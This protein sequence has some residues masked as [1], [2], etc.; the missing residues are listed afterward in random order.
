MLLCD[1]VARIKVKMHVFRTTLKHTKQFRETN[2]LRYVLLSFEV[3]FMLDMGW[4]Y[5]FW[6]VLLEPTKPDVFKS[7][8]FSI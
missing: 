8:C 1:V 3:S 7:L 5:F 4:L 6:N 2:Q